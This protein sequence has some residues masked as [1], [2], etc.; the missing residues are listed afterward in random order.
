MP[1]MALLYEVLL[2]HLLLLVLSLCHMMNLVKLV[3]GERLRS[4]L[5]VHLIDLMLLLLKLLLLKEPLLILLQM[6]LLRRGKVLKWQVRELRSKIL[7]R[8]HRGRLLHLRLLR[9]LAL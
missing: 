2:K 1:R 8:L 3:M 4:L 6:L 5:L 9:C 7:L